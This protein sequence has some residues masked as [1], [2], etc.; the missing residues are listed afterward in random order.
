MVDYG[1]RAEAVLLAVM[2]PDGIESKA[3]FTM[4]ASRF[5]SARKYDG[6]TDFST[7]DTDPQFAGEEGFVVKW[8]SGF[9]A[10]CK[11]TEYK[12]LH[13]LITQC[14]TRTIWELLRAGGD[15]KE[16]TDRVP[17]EFSEW[18]NLQAVEMLTNR[19]MLEFEAQ[20]LIDT[21]KDDF[22]T[23]KDFA[24]WAIQQNNPQ[25]LFALLDGKDI[26]DACWK[27]VE[28]KWSTPFRKGSDEE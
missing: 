4:A 21:R 14:S 24:A 13:R 2:L 17:P 22:R 27:L 12:R 20:R 19:T 6:V 10:K 8:E 5:N 25:L 11:L 7:I 18:V 28:P 16:I 15:T 26:K 1:D 3:L 23:R 9:M